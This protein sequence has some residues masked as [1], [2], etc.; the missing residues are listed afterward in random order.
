MKY[1]CKLFGQTLERITCLT[2]RM[3]QIISKSNCYYSYSI[4]IYIKLPDMVKPTHVINFISIVIVKRENDS[5]CC[6]KLSFFLFFFFNENADI[7]NQDQQSKWLTF[8]I[9]TSSS[10]NK[11]HII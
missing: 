8:N 1:T 10:I 3:R 11:L 5:V 9:T 2:P 7:K 6:L 4:Q